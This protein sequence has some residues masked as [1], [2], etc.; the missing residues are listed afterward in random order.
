MKAAMSLF[1]EMK[2]SGLF[3]VVS[4]NILLK[5]RDS[6]LANSEALLEDMFTHGLRPN[7]T[8][9]NSLLVNA[10][11]VGDFQRT[12]QT[13]DHMESS[14][15][16]VDAYTISILFKGCKR[17]PRANAFDTRVIDR[18]L[19]LV[20]KYNVK[21]D[22]VLVNAALEAC[23]NLRD[24]GKLT[25]AFETFRRSGWVIPK[26]CAMHTYGTLIK[27]YGRTQQLDVAWGLWQEVCDREFG[28]SEQLYG[29]MIDVLVS[30]DRMDDALA[31]FLDM[32]KSHASHL[33]SQ[34]FAVAYAILIRGFAKRKEC[35]RA[36]RYYEEMKT[37]GTEVGLVVFNTL[38]DACSRVGNME[39]STTLFRAM[40]DAQCVP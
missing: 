13:I 30:N 2:A 40:V 37:H 16:G 19:E 5:R 17:D 31:L 32:K 29:Q 28:A 23:I 38:I 22:E 1:N 20:K 36:L 6:P 34:G 18:A 21:V 27:A 24:L 35:N 14:G 9:Y 8:T 3:D 4:Y 33:A 7:L 39:V 26:Q 10:L 25:A 11:A 15:Q 12:W